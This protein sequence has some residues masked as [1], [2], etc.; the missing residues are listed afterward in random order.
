MNAIFGLSLDDR[1][2]VDTYWNLIERVV[3]D[4]ARTAAKA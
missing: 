4:K 3:F 1:S 2:A